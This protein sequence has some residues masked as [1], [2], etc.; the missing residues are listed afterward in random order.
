MA[1]ALISTW[2]DDFLSIYIFPGVFYD[3]FLLSEARNISS[4]IAYPTDAD[5][6]KTLQS[7]I[8]HIECTSS[9]S[10]EPQHTWWPEHHRHML[11]KLL[12]I[13]L[14]PKVI[15]FPRSACYSSR[16]T[17]TVGL[18]RLHLEQGVPV[19]H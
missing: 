4:G 13:L 15:I 1:F 8:S 14:T 11:L 6:R 9:R 19:T 12:R 17:F 2:I 5:R 10:S 3:N 16:D 18:Y 7:N